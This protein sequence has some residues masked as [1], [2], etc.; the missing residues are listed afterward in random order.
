MASPKDIPPN[1]Q[2]IPKRNA[3]QKALDRALDDEKKMLGTGRVPEIKGISTCVN[4]IFIKQVKIEK[5]SGTVKTPII[6]GI[7][8]QAKDACTNQNVPHDHVFIF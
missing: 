8:I 7:I 6:N 2:A 3:A 1:P 4:D 5:K